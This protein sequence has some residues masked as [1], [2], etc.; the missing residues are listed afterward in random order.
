MTITGINHKITFISTTSEHTMEADI[1]FT[2]EE[3]AATQTKRETVYTE[4]LKFRLDQETI[5]Q[6]R[7]LIDSYGITDW[8]GKTPALPKIPEERG[9]LISHLLTLKFDDG[10]TA[11]ITLREVSEEIGKEASEKFRKLFFE[12]VKEDKKISEE[13][14]YPTLKDCRELKEEHGP[15][16][17]VETSTFENG[18]MYNSNIWR[19]RTIEKIPD[20]EGIVR[21]TLYRKQGN[22]PE[23]TDIREVASDIFTKVQEIS[24]RENLPSWNY[25]ATD[26]SLPREIVFDYTF[27]ASINIY[28]DD[29]L[30]TGAPRVK[31]TIGE[32]A[33]KM[34]GNEV[35]KQLSEL[36]NECVAASGAKIEE[37][38]ANPFLYTIDEVNKQPGAMPM[39]GMGMNQLASMQFQ[40]AMNEMRTTADNPPV[41]SA[42]NEPWNCSCGQTGLT[43]KF[44]PE[45]GNPRC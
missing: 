32:A 34:G 38:T 16:I 37:S 42:S 13:K 27:I 45:C 3:L 44:C 4:I 28:Y 7:N 29:T 1:P 12:T 35:D 18:M 26:P 22:L 25:A 6:Y 10:T 24:D 43:C 31:R 39:A 20:K 17:A 40:Q 21:V 11:K 5:D 33:C 8:I 23:Q 19:T 15:V 41:Q 36:I 30:I 2:G 14:I 9:S